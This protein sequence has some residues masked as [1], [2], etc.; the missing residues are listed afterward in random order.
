MSTMDVSCGVRVLDKT[1][2]LLGVVEAGPASL[3]ALS[4]A[5]GLPRQ[6]ANRLAIAMERLGLFTRD[7]AGRFILGPRLADLSVEARQPRLVSVAAPVLSGLRDL[8]GMNVQLYRRRGSTRVC[9]YSADS[10]L[11]PTGQVRVGATFSLKA[12]S[13]SQ[14]LLA[15]DEPSCLYEA[16]VGARFN[17][18]TLSEVRR[19]G[20]A[21]SVG[22]GDP[23]VAWVAAPVRGPGK[24]VLAAVAVSG[25]VTRMSRSPGRLYARKVI[26]AA[27]LI[28][29]ELAR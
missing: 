16:V 1:S 12:G 4:A 9:M 14:V 23:G 29:D 8:T 18:G 7:A 24:G 25:P 2:L 19:Q 17:I 6:T 26:D 5:T 3:A 22:N 11:G 28:G 27:I 15:W 21:Q 13:I 20:W 10:H